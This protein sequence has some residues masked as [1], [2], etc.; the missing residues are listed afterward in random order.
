MTTS[1][2]SLPDRPN[3][4]FLKDRAKAMVKEGR[5]PSLAQAQHTLA[6]TYGFANWAMLKAHIEPL[7]AEQRLAAT[8]RLI[9]AALDGD[10]KNLDAALRA[11]AN[12]KHVYDGGESYDTFRPPLKAAIESGQLEAVRRLLDH[13]ALDR[14]W[15][16]D[17]LQ[18]ARQRGHYDIAALLSERRRAEVDLDAAIRRGDLEAIEALLDADP[19]LA[20]ANEAG[21][22]AQPAPIY[23]AAQQGDVRVVRRLIQAGADPAAAWHASSFN[24]M[25]VARYQDNRALI[26]LLESHHVTSPDVTDFLYAAS[27]GDLDRVRKF[28]DAGMG[29]N[30]KCVCEHH[31]IVHA[32]RSGNAS[33]LQLVLDRGAD[34]RLSNG[35]EGTIWFADL[36]EAGNVDAVR[37]ILDLGYDVNHRDAHGN[38]PLSIARQAGQ[39][40]VEDLLLAY[41]DQTKG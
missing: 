26:E 28:L 19:T 40:A 37:Q 34:I 8:H 20:R 30:A 24:A 2:V 41:A 36:I 7:Q 18:D 17:G 15:H 25:T 5:A 35:W 14:A 4:R 38:T 6:W 13:G 9:Q 22:A 1:S 10:L 33:V 21:H 39:Q 16:W 23:L 27:Q 32:F 29:V 31:V 11:G 3:L 12:A